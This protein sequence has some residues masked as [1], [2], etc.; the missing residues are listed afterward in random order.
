MTVEGRM[1]KSTEQG[2]NLGRSTV[3]TNSGLK[4]ENVFLF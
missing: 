4:V 1:E 2:L 3:C